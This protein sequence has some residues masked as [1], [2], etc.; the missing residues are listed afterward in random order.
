[1][2]GLVALVV[3]LEEGLVG[4]R[5]DGEDCIFFL[6]CLRTEVLRIEMGFCCRDEHE[7]GCWAD[8]VHL[9]TLMGCVDAVSKDDGSGSYMPHDVMLSSA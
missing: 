6:V 1:M 3:L 7:N 2:V 4:E 9:L 8:Q 5:L